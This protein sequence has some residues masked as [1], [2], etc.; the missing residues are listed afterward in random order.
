MG[1][2]SNFIDGDAVE[3]YHFHCP[4]CGFAHRVNIRSHNKFVNASIWKF[5]GNEE[6]PTFTP[7]IKVEWDEYIPKTDSIIEH[8]CHSFITKGKIRFLN[9]CTHKLAG[10]EV[11]L[12]EFLGGG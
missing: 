2:I 10:Q 6:T 5:N 3:G 11:E 8:I 7:S 12:P 4:G 9:N 1:K